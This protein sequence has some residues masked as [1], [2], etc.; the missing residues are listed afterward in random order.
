MIPETDTSMLYALSATQR[1]V[2]AEAS[3]ARLPDLYIEQL[4]ATFSNTVCHSLLERAWQ[5]VVDHSPVL[6]ASIQQEHMRDAKLRVHRNCVVRIPRVCLAHSDSPAFALHYQE[7]RQRGFRVTEQPLHRLCLYDLPHG[8]CALVFTYHHVILDGSSRLRALEQLGAA[9]RSLIKDNELP[10]MQRGIGSPLSIVDWCKIQDVKSAQR[11]WREFLKNLNSPAIAPRMGREPDA[12]GNVSG[13]ATA[14]LEF[15]TESTALLRRTAARMAVPLN[16]VI[17]GVWAA[18]LARTGRGSSVLFGRTVSLEGRINSAATHALGVC[19]NIVPA[20]ANVRPDHSIMDLAALLHSQRIETI[21]YE[22]LALSDVQE[23]APEPGT[24]LIHSI[25]VWEPDPLK[26][27]EG[28]ANGGTA[29]TA[30]ALSYTGFAIV[31]M[32][33]LEVSLGLSVIVQ[34]PWGDA[35]LA[36]AIVL[37]MQ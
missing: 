3:A 7:E 17:E 15:T 36:Q 30:N 4:V 24:K 11:Y 10:G 20:Y 29:S 33:R 19:V 35:P 28:L 14:S 27:L 21:G 31:V 12:I 25:I 1:A 9:Y 2:L 26:A 16:A 13:H 18:V 6:R 8:G 22:H 37:W 23:C 5:Y 34:K 32:A